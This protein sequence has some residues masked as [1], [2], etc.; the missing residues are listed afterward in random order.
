MFNYY[1]NPKNRQEIR[2]T[3]T[4]ERLITER[5]SE[6]RRGLILGV[7]NIGTGIGTNFSD[8]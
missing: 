7:G 1:Y 2:I 6:D 5:E 4:T 8:I 3:S